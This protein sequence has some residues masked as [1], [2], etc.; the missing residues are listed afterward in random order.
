[1]DSLSVIIPAYNEEDSMDTCLRQ[2]SDF[3]FKKNI[4]SEIIVVNDGSVDLTSQVLKVWKDRVLIINNDQNRGKGYSV[5]HGLLAGQY[6]WLFFLDADLSTP[7]SELNKFFV[8][9]SASDAIIG[10]RR[11]VASNII[12]PQPRIKD[13]AG[14]FGNKLIKKLSR[15]SYNDTQCGFKAFHC[16]LKP[17]IRKITLDGW[18]FDVELLYILNKH[19]KIVQEVPVNWTN[20]LDSK[21]KAIDYFNTLYELVKIRQN[22]KKGLY[23]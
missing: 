14:R 20:N 9:H 21:V 13:L 5:K 1:M 23:I 18:G 6:E 15:L 19:K 3:L 8:H 7:I 10:S 12:Q 16:R 17:L 11:V 2:V 4:L 22:D